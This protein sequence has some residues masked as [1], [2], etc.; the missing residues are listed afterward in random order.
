MSSATAAVSNIYQASLKGSSIAEV[1]AG[2]SSS[3]G[4][5]PPTPPSSSSSCATSNA[6][7]APLYASLPSTD[8]T[9]SLLG[10]VEKLPIKYSE[11]DMGN[12]EDIVEL[13]EELSQY[14]NTS[15]FNISSGSIRRAALMFLMFV[16]LTCVLNVSPNRVSSHIRTAFTHLSTDLVDPTPEDS[17]NKTVAQ[18]NPD[19]FVDENGVSF[20]PG[21][22]PGNIEN[23][24]LKPGCLMM[25][26]NDLTT[27]SENKDYSDSKILTICSS[28]AAGVVMVDNGLLKKYG[29]VGEDKSYVSSVLFSDDSQLKLFSGKN[30][31]GAVI[32]SNGTP[33]TDPY[34]KVLGLSKQKYV[35][36]GEQVNDNVYSFLFATSSIEMNSCL[37]A[38]EF[39]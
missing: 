21:R 5:I 16:A 37:E 2:S 3:S 27:L 31:D 26:V 18:V 20:C 29:M 34:T 22:L 13:Q 33:Y 14:Y 15:S 9:S 6:L 28:M 8:E 35:D 25:S 39:N 32:G 36:S 10:G 30:F 38:M 7:T 23:V 19:C 1:P 4:S 12:E 11:I 24:H 17:A